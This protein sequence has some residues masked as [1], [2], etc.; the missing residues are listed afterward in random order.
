MKFLFNV[1]FFTLCYFISP[2]ENTTS[3][4]QEINT[5]QTEKTTAPALIRRPAPKRLSNVDE[6]L[7]LKCQTVDL[8]SDLKLNNKKF[9]Q[10]QLNC[11]LEEGPCDELGSTL[12]SKEN[13]YTQ[14]DLLATNGKKD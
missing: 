4:E 1:V 10:T 12:K 11:I 7:D 13:S 3:Y 2:I 6:F 8:V 14:F 5:V 9:V